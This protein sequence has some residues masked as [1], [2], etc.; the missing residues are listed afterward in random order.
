MNIL[1]ERVIWFFKN[2]IAFY[3]VLFVAMLVKNFPFGFRYFLFSD[4]YNQYGVYSI[5]AE[6][7]WQNVIVPFNIFGYRPLAGITDVYIISRLWGNIEWVLLAI[8]IMHFISIVLLGKIFDRSKIIWGKIA[9]IFFSFYPTLTESAYWISASSRIVIAAFFAILA[10]YAILKFIY[11]EGR[12]WVW[13]GVAMVCGILAQGYYE[14]G[15]VFSF[16]LS[17]GVL[18]LHRRT[19]TNKLLF[20]WPILNTA[21]IGV[22]YYIF[23]NVGWFGMR[24]ETPDSGFFAQVQTVFLRIGATFVREQGPTIANSLRWGISDLF[25]SHTFVA[26]LIVIFSLILATFIFFD[27]KSEKPIE[28]KNVLLSLLAAFILT[29]STF[30]IFFLLSD[31]WIW[32]RNFFYAV[33]GMA[34]FAEIASRFIK[35]KIIKTVITFAATLIFFFGFVL[36]VQS[37]KFIDKYDNIIVGNLVEQSSQLGII[38]EDNIWLFGVQWNYNSSSI[39]PRITSQTRVDW[40]IHGHLLSLQRRFHFQQIFPIMH[41]DVTNEGFEN[42]F[43]FGLDEELNT[44]QLTFDG[45][46][47]TFT[48][49]NETFGTIDS[50]GIFSRTQR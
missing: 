9:V 13:F 15:I 20:V 28:K 3:A 37:L 46:N 43:L 11:K 31:S 29:A 47:L 45:Y 49:N 25:S 5:W 39:N 42:G 7:L 6:D 38:P 23:R 48:D 14:Q 12:Y 40:A 30:S 44:R 33:I 21:I 27:K 22:H 8:V 36:E 1:K 41:G 2:D 19:I 35:I 17:M 26:V 10:V 18:I 16:V 4:D 50:E 32:V 34:I 24:A